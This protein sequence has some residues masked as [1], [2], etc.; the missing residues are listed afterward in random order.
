MH[1]VD[2]SM[3]FA[4]E[5]GGVGRYLAVKHAWLR[6]NTRWRHTIVAPGP[7]RRDEDGVRMYRAPVPVHPY[8]FPLARAIWSRRLQRLAPD[9]LEAGDPFV[10]AWAA[11]DAGQRLGIPVV[12]FY[13]SD[14]V[15]TV[16]LRLG[17]GGEAL[18]RRYAR[19][20]YR[21]FDLVVAPSRSAEHRLAELGL[22]KLACQP[23]GV[24][25]QAFHPGRGCIDLRARLGLP[26]TTRL[27]VFAGRFAREKNLDVLFDAMRVLGDPY[28]LVLIGSGHAP[29]LPANA[30]RLPYQSDARAFA[31]LLAS[32]D[33][34]VHAGDRETFGLIVLE[35]MA[36]GLPVV[37]VGGG[38]ITELVETHGVVVGRR[39]A[40]ALADA[41]TSL[42]AADPQA[43]G[44]RG[45][46]W[47]ERHH[48]WDHSLRGLAGLYRRVSGAA[49]G[50]WERAYAAR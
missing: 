18:A 27:L 19:A 46:E 43:V 10:L 20:L 15:A 4:P 49:A 22:A 41:V 21:E 40:R 14:V 25:V 36:C 24:D 48:T 16:A 38:A 33:A 8:R 12:A 17:R 6:A 13:H 5:G 47:V 2:T 7:L 31:A 9:L 30:T 1:L 32:C 44:R 26:R 29:P 45:R 39:D 34:F 3:F 35:A 28:H 11:A 42:F 50:A 23:L 37:A